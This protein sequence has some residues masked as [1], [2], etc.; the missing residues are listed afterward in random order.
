MKKRNCFIL[1]YVC[2][3]VYRYVY[4]DSWKSEQGISCLELGLWAIVNHWMW[5]LGTNS[6]LL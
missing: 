4:G 5:V 6:G 1:Y 2:V 3:S